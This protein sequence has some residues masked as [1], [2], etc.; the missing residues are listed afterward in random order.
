MNTNSDE[1]WCDRQ[2]HHPRSPQKGSHNPSKKPDQVFGNH[3]VLGVLSGIA[4]EVVV[5][6]GSLQDELSIMRIRDRWPATVHV[7]AAVAAGLSV[8]STELGPIADGVPA[9]GNLQ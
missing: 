3:T 7:V 9:S 8:F 1:S 4:P 6:V 5:L 2:H